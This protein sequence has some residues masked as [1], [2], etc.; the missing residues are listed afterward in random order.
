MPSTVAVV[1]AAIALSACGNSSHPNEPRPPVPTTLTVTINPSEV[2]ISPER[3]GFPGE[4]QQNI[5]QNDNAAPVKAN[6]KA[7]FAVRGAI[8]NLTRVNTRL[9][10]EGPVDKTIPITASGSANFT[11][12]LPTGIYR[13]S[14]PVSLGTTLLTVGRTRNSS[15]TDVLTP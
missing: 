12:A 8:A 9:I 1:A 13:L 2:H 5:S 7:P 6:P 15:A 11:A 14:S 4:Q 3:L 10:L